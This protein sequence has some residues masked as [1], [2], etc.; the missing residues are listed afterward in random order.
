MKLKT[1]HTP[2]ITLRVR[3]EAE[4]QRYVWTLSKFCYIK[5]TQKNYF[6]HM[7]SERGQN[8]GNHRQYV[9]NRLPIKS[10]DYKKQHER[11]RERERVREKERETE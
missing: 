9:I 2:T 7:H 11:E 1:Q 3:A 4:G 10:S 8:N 5:Y 6:M